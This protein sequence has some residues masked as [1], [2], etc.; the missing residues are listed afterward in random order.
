LDAVAV[1]LLPANVLLSV[2]FTDWKY[3]FIVPVLLEPEPEPAFE[4]FVFDVG[5]P[6]KLLVVL[7]A[8]EIPAGATLDGSS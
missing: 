5:A 6:Q 4:F 7:P 3:E 8:F 1:L 2:L